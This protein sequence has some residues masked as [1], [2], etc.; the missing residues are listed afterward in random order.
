MSSV[1]VQV[2]GCYLARS[3][4]PD[5]VKEAA[6]GG[7]VTELLRHALREDLVDVVVCVERGADALD[8]RPIVVDDPA[9]VPS[10]SYHCAPTQL[11]RLVAEL[12]REDPTLRVAVTCRP[13]DARTLDR[14]AE[15]DLVNPDRVYRIGLNCGGTF[16]PR[17]VLEILEEHGVD[18]LDVER[19]EVVKGHL[20]IEL[21]DGEEISVSI[22]EL[23]EQ[24]SGRRENCR[25]CD[26]NIPERADLACGNWGVPDDL[27]GEWTFVEVKTEDG[28]DLLAG[29]LDAGTME[30][31]EAPGKSVQIRA[32]IDEVM[33]K[34]AR[35]W[36][37]KTLDE[38]WLTEAIEALDRCI[39][40]RSCRQVCPVC[41]SCEEGCWSFAG[42][43]SVTP[44]PV[45]HA[46]IAQC[47]ALYCVECGA[48]E[49]AC[50]AEIPLT[51]IYSV[52]R[53][54]LPD[55]VERLAEPAEE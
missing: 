24:D 33:R 29:A 19:E 16:E 18:P 17:V 36:R 49:T 7:V 35:S 44:T 5:T 34:M 23:E 50:P 48:C 2:G 8:G 27:Q 6:C 47:V 41:A 53:E 15:R 25:R 3:S 21:R 45:W 40:C 54:R 13:C 1:E 32:K 22:D 42:R 9:E 10:G 43:E 14:L 51:R 38:D 30:V 46:H 11:A 20:V 12:H 37:E 55:V 26:E 4:D 31:Q 52:L 28:R 39:K